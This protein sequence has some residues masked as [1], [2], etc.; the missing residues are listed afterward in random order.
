LGRFN[1]L[2]LGGLIAHLPFYSPSLWEKYRGGA[3]MISSPAKYGVDGVVAAW[4]HP[5]SFSFGL[6]QLK[7]MI[8]N[9]QVVAAPGFT[10]VMNWDRRVMAGAQAARFFNKICELLRH[11]AE[12]T[13]LS[14]SK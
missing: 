14:I 5:L 11:P 13:G 10:F 8:S 9:N 2:G 3:V 1:F 12:L 7:P 6:V 4:T